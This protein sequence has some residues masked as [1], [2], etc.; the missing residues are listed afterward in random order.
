MLGA[1]VDRGD[2]AIPVWMKQRRTLH[3]GAT[4][5]TDRLVILLG[6][7]NDLIL[8]CEL[9]REHGRGAVVGVGAKPTVDRMIVIL[10][11]QRE[12]ELRDRIDVFSR[13]RP[14]SHAVELQ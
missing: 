1:N 4:D 8:S 13:R 6:E 10:A 9:R 7:K 14:D 5:D 3:V 2:V 12:A 11:Q